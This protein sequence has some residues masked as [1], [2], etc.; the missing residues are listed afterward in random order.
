MRNIF[1][2]ALTGIGLLFSGA[3]FAQFSVDGQIIQRGE[4]RHGYGRLIN[5]EGDAAMFI[6]QR[7]RVNAQYKMDNFKF[8]VS[9]QDVRTWGNTPQIKATDPF[10]SVHE[11]WA[12]TNIGSNFTLRLGRQEL[13]YDNARFL[14]NLDWA[15]QG[16]AHDFALAK[17]EKES[18]K[19]HFGAGY[20][21]DEERLSGTFYTTPRQYKAAQFVRY[22]N[23]VGEK[24]NFSLLFWN[25]GLQYSVLNP[26]NVITEE[27]IRYMQTLGIPTL[28]YQAG[29]TTLS[30]FYYHQ[31]GEDVSG[32]NVNAFDAS[33]QVSHQLEFDPEKGNK[34]R[35]TAG[36]EV[37]SG[38]DNNATGNVNKSFSPLYGTNHAHNGYMDYF[39]VGG[40]HDHS[41]GLK[42]IYIRARYDVNPA[43]FL[44]LNGHSFSTYGDVYQGREELDKNLGVEL[45]FT[46]GYLINDAVSVQGGYSQMFASETMEALQNIQNPANIQNWG[47]IMMIYRPT[48]KNRFI[49]LLF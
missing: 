26:A 45:D 13:N 47:Y 12:E 38:T 48:M 24:V 2:V 25:N 18:M 43:L 33:V 23:V 46:L 15:L 35:L 19:L 42:D 20:N 30:G 3:A 34:L 17:Y 36:F 27:G 11:A 7:A 32:R 21:Q 49:G 40:R 8:Y 39:Y 6:G 5:E 44:S 29:N 4:Y 16:R 1:K 37:L 22:E 31:F 28:K 14:G 41:V 10:L 9:I